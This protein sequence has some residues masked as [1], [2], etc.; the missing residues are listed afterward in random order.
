MESHVHHM[1]NGP[2]QG[3]KHYFFE[4]LMLFLA[5]FCGFL[6]ENIRE[7]G[8]ERKKEK[9]YMRSLWLDLQEDTSSLRD[10]SSRFA[11]SNKNI[12]TLIRILKSSYKNDSTC[13]IY[14]LAM[15]IPF[16]DRI[17]QPD[18]KTFE[19]LKNS[20]NLRLIHNNELLTKIGAYY[21]RYSQMMIGGPGQML[22]QN[23]HDL[24]LF[25]YELFDMAVFQKLWQTSRSTL[26]GP[27][28][29]DSCTEKPVLLT[30]DPMVINKICARYYY[31]EMTR[32]VL[33]QFWLTPSLLQ[34]DSLLANLQDQYHFR[35]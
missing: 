6:A 26:R 33:S 5:V 4:F 9:Q 19:Q 13:K 24:Y 31:I 7:H 2:S 10:I 17:P 30:N 29:I 20:G 14:R 12:D 16:A 34:A 27:I 1:H 35:N 18:N 15:T 8:V 3:W 28:F 32:S 21:N 23:R 22:F 25:T 11:Q